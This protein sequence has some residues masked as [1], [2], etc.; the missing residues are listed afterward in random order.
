MAE[1]AHPNMP[2]ELTEQ[3]VSI[4]SGTNLVK[5]TD[6]HAVASTPPSL[7]ASLSLLKHR[8]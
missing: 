2:A 1:K 7:A 8:I 6:A 5:G 3:I 4:S